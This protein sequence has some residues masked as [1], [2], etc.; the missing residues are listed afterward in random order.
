M[1]TSKGLAE[2]LNNEGLL[3]H[4]VALV[5]V[6]GH[7]SLAK[8]KVSASPIVR[9]EVDGGKVD[10]ADSMIGD[11]ILSCLQRPSDAVCDRVCPADVEAHCKKQEA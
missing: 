9:P 11:E 3:E 8:V 1:L 6:G 5:D 7:P 4:D 2:L 10:G